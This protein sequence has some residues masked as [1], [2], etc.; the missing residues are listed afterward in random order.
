MSACYVLCQEA[1]VRDYRPLFFFKRWWS[2]PSYRSFLNFP[3]IFFFRSILSGNLLCEPGSLLFLYNFPDGLEPLCRIQ[4]RYLLFSI[5]SNFLAPWH[6]LYLTTKVC[7]LIWI[8]GIMI[9]PW[10]FAF[11]LK[12]WINEWEI[13]SNFDYNEIC[14]ISEKNVW[15]IVH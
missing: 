3:P 12:R 6:I 15:H 2:L 4:I 7:N 8:A 14:A 13:F 11:V 10:I 5:C 9:A 1:V